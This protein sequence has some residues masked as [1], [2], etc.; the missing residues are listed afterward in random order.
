[1]KKSLLFATAAMLLV[2][3]LSISVLSQDDD[4]VEHMLNP[5]DHPDGTMSFT[6]SGMI[7]AAL[8]TGGTSSTTPLVDHGGP[9]IN[10]PMIYP[11]LVRQ[12]ESIQWVRH[13][14]GT[15]AD[16]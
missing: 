11:H 1:M 4:H 16:S 15:A 8:T 2:A 12:L 6:R 10:T 7:K 14:R 3:Q 9:V 13:A 5:H